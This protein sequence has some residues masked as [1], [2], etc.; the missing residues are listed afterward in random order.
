M[1][2]EKEKYIPILSMR[3]SEIRALEHL[4]DEDKNRVTPLIDIKRY[5]SSKRSEVPDELISRSFGCRRII[6]N[7]SSEVRSDL[8]EK[9]KDIPLLVHLANLH[10]PKG[11]YQNWVTYTASKENYIPCLQIEEIDLLSR[12]VSNFLEAGKTELVLRIPYPVYVPIDDILKILSETTWQHIDFLCLVDIGEID[13]NYQLVQSGVETLLTRLYE[14]NV[15][16]RICVS[17]RSFPSYFASIK[18]QPIY[19]RYLFDSLK[20]GYPDLVYG[21]YGSSRVNRIGGGGSP[22]VY[23]RIDL[24]QMTRWEFERHDDGVDR[25]LQENKDIDLTDLYRTVARRYLS[26]IPQSPNTWGEKLILST[27]VGGGYRGNI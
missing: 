4:S 1:G 13:K 3:P 14:A 11:G 23:P 10:S 17:S 20:Q 9:E 7:L 16:S 12:Q 15:F 24:P 19:E 5:V 21:D 22:V 6:V 2:Y 8:T 25:R 18:S 27:A 26:R